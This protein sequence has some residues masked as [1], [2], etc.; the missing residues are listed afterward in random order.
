MRIEI[1]FEAFNVTNEKNWTN[2]DGNQRS[3]TFGRPSNGENTRQVQ[4][5]VRV[6]F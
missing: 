3:A 2:F 4:L 1:I 6:D 5:G